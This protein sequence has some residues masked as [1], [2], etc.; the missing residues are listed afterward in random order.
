M[1]VGVGREVFSRALLSGAQYTMG[2]PRQASDGG[3]EGMGWS[4][5]VERR[6]REEGR[7]REKKIG[8]AF[9]KRGV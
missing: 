7:E 3:R 1:V 9:W 6:E 8:G 5:E 4:R 2:P